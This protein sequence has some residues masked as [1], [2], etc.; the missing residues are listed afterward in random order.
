M[1]KSAASAKQKAYRKAYYAKNKDKLL[2]ANLK[3]QKANPE[4]VKAAKEAWRKK[5]PDKIKAYKKKYYQKNKDKVRAATRKWQKD[6][7]DKVRK[8]AQ[9]TLARK[10]RR[11]VTNP[12]ICFQHILNTA[13]SRAKKHN[14]AFGIDLSY[15]ENLWKRQNGRC[16]VS[17]QKMT[18]GVLSNNKNL[19][20]IDRKNSNK[21]YIKGNCQL[22]TAVVNK[23]KLNLDSKTFKSICK[24]IAAH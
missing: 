22:V 5:N 20:S 18:T 17:G 9:R 4:K 6:N 23:M 24:A 7:P 3:W 10:K 2:E 16:N 19:V 21:G 12:Q 14:R 15:I 1:S 11:S 8:T 13:K